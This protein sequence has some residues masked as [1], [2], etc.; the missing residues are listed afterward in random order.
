MYDTPIY[1]TIS[2]PSK[3]FSATDVTYVV[4]GPKGMRG[5][6][7]DVQ[8]VVTVTCAG[9]TTKPKLQVGLSGALTT[10]A[11][12]DMGT[13]AAGAAKRASQTVGDLKLTNNNLKIIDADTD[14]YITLKAA[15]GAGAAG[16]IVP[17][18]MFQWF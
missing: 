9:A 14:V 13:T 5:K 2:F 12:M 15:T 3:D 6:L 17:M 16:T 10:Y 18:F 11:D 8:G 7:Y 1:E 4:R